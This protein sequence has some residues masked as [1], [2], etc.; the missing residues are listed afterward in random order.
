MIHLLTRR[1]APAL[2]L[3]QVA[4]VSLLQIAFMT[5]RPDTAELD[6]TDPAGFS[7]LDA[8]LLVLTLVVLTGGAV[9]LG[10]E[11]VRSRVPRALTV[12]WPALVGLGQTLLGVAGLATYGR[13]AGL[14]PP[15]ALLFAAASV[16]VAVA[17]ASTIRTVLA[18]VRA[19]T[20]G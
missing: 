5:L 4:Y 19:S 7:L 8:A 9:L 16:A 18:P 1:V 11:R 2:L 15:V 12:A 14:G 20:V 3:L 13:P 6:H 17:C 10:L